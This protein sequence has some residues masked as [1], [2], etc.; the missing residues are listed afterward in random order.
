[1]EFIA[2]LLSGAATASSSTPFT[3]F[4]TFDEPECPQELL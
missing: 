2:K 1:M 3:A 4:F